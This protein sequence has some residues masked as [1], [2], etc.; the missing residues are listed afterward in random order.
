MEDISHKVKIS[1]LDHLIA[2]KRSQIDALKISVKSVEGY[3]IGIKELAASNEGFFSQHKKETLDLLSQ[4][5]I[6]VEAYKLAESLLAGFLLINKNAVVDVERALLGRQYEIN[7]LEREVIALLEHK[8][9]LE[10]ELEAVEVAGA[11]ERRRER[12]VRPDQDTGSKIG[13]AALDIAARKKGK[14]SP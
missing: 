8:S 12:G 14:K 13:R 5:K 3:A 6:D 2:Q 10:K 1:F 9:S 7:F 4:G 11:I